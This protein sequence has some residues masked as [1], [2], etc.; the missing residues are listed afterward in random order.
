M[1]CGITAIYSYRTGSSLVDPR[2]L[3]KISDQMAARGPDGEGSWIS[4]DKKIGFAHKRLAIIDTTEGGSQPMSLTNGN[5]EVRLVITYN[6]EI[7][8][9]K[10][11]RE[12]LISDGLRF[13]TQSD[14]EV[15]L[16]LYDRFGSA[17]VARLR[18]MFAFAIWD[19]EKQ[20]LFLARDPFG[21]KPLYYSDVGGVFRVASQVKALLAGNKIPTNPEPAGHV[22]FFSYGYIPEPYTLY[23]NILALPSGHTL[24]V[25]SNG[26]SKIIKYYDPLETLEKVSSNSKNVDGFITIKNSLLDSIKSHLVSDVPVGVFLSAGLDSATLT[27]FASQLSQDPLNTVTLQFEELVGTL[28]DEA[29]LAEEISSLYNTNHVTSTVVGAEFY[30]ELRSMLNAMDQ[31]SIDGANTYFVAREAS[32]LGL[33]VA[34]SGLGG[35][36]VFGGYSSFRQIPLLVNLLRWVP[37]GEFAG[38]LLRR[39]ASPFLTKLISPK[40]LSLLEYGGN[41]SGAYLLRRGLF[42]P[43]ELP[44]VIDSD[45]ALEGWEKLNFIESTNKQL[46]KIKHSK[47]RVSALELMW[48]MRNQLLRDSDW[49][50]MAHSLEIRTPL[51]DS[52]FFSELGALSATKLD[53]A[54]SLDVPLPKSVLNRPKTGFYLPIREWLTANGLQ[55]YGEGYKGWA[56]MVYEHFVSRP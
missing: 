17:M 10:E 27:G 53:M 51:V 24:T 13:T 50:G 45:M 33:K 6:G 49:A 4:A 3:A 14:T 8:N 20:K 35:D 46:S 18:G 26:A 52:V 1:M 40:Y 23:K 28:A 32:K 44:A 55:N 39:S 7:Y 34:L 56:K 29:P 41:Y 12:E 42:M 9:F 43:W 5:G 37:Y 38:R 54:Q 31:P 16:H 22:G 15:L 19:N 2:E 47:A 30:S 21:I 11:L 25:G 48:Y 36:E